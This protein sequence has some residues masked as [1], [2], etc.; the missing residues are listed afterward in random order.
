MKNLKKIV[1]YLM[2][3]MMGVFLFSS[4]KVTNVLAYET[5]KFETTNGYLEY[6]IVNDNKITIRRYDGTDKKLEIPSEIDGKSVT[7][8]ADYAFE[9]NVLSYRNNLTDIIIPSS[10]TSIGKNVFLFCSNLENVKVNEDNET[11]TD[12]N[13]VLLS[14]DK[15]ILIYYPEGKKE[16]TYS[17]PNSVTSIEEDAFQDCSNLTSI[18]IP[19]SVT[20]IG[21][22]AFSKC[23]NLK[24]ITMSNSVTNIEKYA[25]ERCNNLTSI[26]I[27]NSVTSIGEYAF[28]G[29]KSLTDI[30][31]PN[32]VT[33]INR[34]TFSGCSS[35]KN[36]A[37]PNAV[38][39]I[40]E[41]AFSGCSSLTNITIPNS[42]T[43]IEACAFSGCES[44]TDIIIPNTITIINRATF[45]G[46]SSLKNIEIPNSVT[47]IR[48]DA[49]EGCSNLTNITI[50]NSVERIGYYAFYKCKSLGN[51]KIPNSVIDIGTDAFLYCN[52][53][54][55]CGYKNSYVETY[56]KRHSIRFKELEIPIAISSFI[57]DKT[58][59]QKIQTKVKLTTQVKFTTEVAK[60][61]TLQ[62]KYY[63]YLNGKYAVIKE[64][65]TANNV[66]IAPKNPGI[67]DICVA[68]KDSEGNIVRKKLIFE[69]V[70]IKDIKPLGIESFTSDKQSP[71]KVGTIVKLTTKISGGNEAIQYKYYRY[72]NGKYALIKDWNTSNTITIAPK[73]IGTYD[74][75]VGVKDSTGNIVRKNIKFTFK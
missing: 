6:Y 14:K 28:S 36:I 26:T 21:K 35:L 40:R 37:I 74:I 70:N 17:I 16:E 29:C 56:A 73:T 50:P 25:F 3:I 67:Y 22:Y 33:V 72:L 4:A 54:T 9:D 10:V 47:N 58:S 60:E 39:S 31:I 30:I 53:L 20:N 46:C 15:T 75:Y 18:I 59:P 27:P 52:N 12:E 23:S 51:I 43:T 66:T 42:V 38:T 41:S 1:S 62:Y 69:F 24:D 71:Q 65:S 34:A 64:W 11:F 44:L 68:V 63:R 5:F 32:S 55:I 7:S 61:E 48:E 19:N 45:D 2:T 13:G 49:F 8:I 57:A